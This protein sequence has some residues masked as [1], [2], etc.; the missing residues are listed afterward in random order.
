[1]A[2]A[3]LANRNGSKFNRGCDTIHQDEIALG[4]KLHTACTLVYGQ[5]QCRR[6]AETSPASLFRQM[7]YGRAVFRDTPRA[8]LCIVT[9][10][11]P[12][13]HCLKAGNRHIV[14]PASRRWGELVR[15]VQRLSL[16]PRWADGWTATAE[17]LDHLGYAI[18]ESIA[19]LLCYSI[20]SDECLLHYSRQQ[21]P[22]AAGDA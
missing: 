20:E 17:A 11:S 4:Q 9:D 15:R 12:F 3:T 5:K 7:R 16:K 2:T 6:I 21:T 22:Q 1:M 19:V 13:V 14:T 8:A 18:A 10:G